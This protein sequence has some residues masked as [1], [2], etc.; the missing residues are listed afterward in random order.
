MRACVR[1]CV[2][3]SVYSGAGSYIVKGE[4]AE[5]LVFLVFVSWYPLP[6]RC[7]SGRRSSPDDSTLLSDSWALTPCDVIPVHY[8]ITQSVVFCHR[9]RKQTKN[10]KRYHDGR[11]CNAMGK[12]WNII[13]LDSFLQFKK[14]QITESGPF[15]PFEKIVSSSP[16]WPWT[17]NRPASTCQGLRLQASHRPPGLEMRSWRGVF[18][19]LFMA[20]FF[21]TARR[22]KQMKGLL[23]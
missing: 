14:A 4:R 17:P 22:W 18:T 23:M 5:L 3:L 13:L 2:C 10:I 7:A 11:K 1:V 9:S 8:K 20:G 16:G 21:V 6:P 15:F 19:L 12:L